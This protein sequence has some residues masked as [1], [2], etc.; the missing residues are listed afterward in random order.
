MTCTFCM[1]ALHCSVAPLQPYLKIIKS[2]PVAKL[3]NSSSEGLEGVRKELGWGNHNVDILPAIQGLVGGRKS[4]SGLGL[5][6][7]F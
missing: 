5:T 7:G 3:G 4:A 2:R 6:A 1:V